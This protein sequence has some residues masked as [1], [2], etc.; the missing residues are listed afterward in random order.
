MNV[1]RLH[2]NWLK[3]YRCD[4]FTIEEPPPEM[5]LRI[6]MG[7]YGSTEYRELAYS[8]NGNDWHF[9]SPLLSSIYKL[10]PKLL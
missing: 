8:R 3:V 5:R 1:P 2:E 4:Y 9:H 10:T 7:Y 6:R